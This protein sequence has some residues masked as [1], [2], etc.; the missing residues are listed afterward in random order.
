MVH[1]HDHA[2]VKWGGGARGDEI[3]WE[4]GGE[5]QFAPPSCTTA[6]RPFNQ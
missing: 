2:G 3:C 6:Y 4:V 5:T 1:N